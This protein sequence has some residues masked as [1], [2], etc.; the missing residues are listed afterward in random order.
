MTRIAATAALRIECVLELAPASTPALA[1]ML[2]LPASTA[3]LAIR[4][5]HRAGRIRPC[6]HT[7]H[8]PMSG[9]RAGAIRW[10]LLRSGDSDSVATLVPTV[11][12]H[13]ASGAAGWSDQ[14][15]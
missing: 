2:A 3:E 11:A 13:S 7:T 12:P 4:N 6:G 9:K 5:L 14:I 15:C 1:R 8:A 10:A